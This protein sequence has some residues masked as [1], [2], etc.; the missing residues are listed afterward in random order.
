MAIRYIWPIRPCGE[1][2]LAH[3]EDRDT[4]QTVRTQ[5][6]QMVVL[7]PRESAVLRFVL[8]GLENK[9]IADELGIAESTVRTYL[10]SLFSA[11]DAH[12]R[13]EVCAWAMTY[14]HALAG[15]AASPHRHADGCNCDS[16]Y[17]TALRQA[18]AE[19]A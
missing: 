6:G 11:V 4:M 3:V 7:S 9:E 10:A 13:V 2:P 1:T 14:P 16:P 8:R 5:Q 19:A 15:I 17:C 18:E 12:N